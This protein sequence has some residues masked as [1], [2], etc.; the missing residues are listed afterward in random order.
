MQLLHIDSAITGNA[1]VS[2]QLTAKTVAA[3]V[4]AH[5][6]TEVQY[7]DLVAQAPGHFTMDAMAPRTGQTDGLSE[8]QQRENAVSES[9]VSQFLAADVVVVGAPFYNFGIPTQLKAWI[10]RIAQPGR[11][12]RYGANGPEGLAKGKTVIVVSS[13]GGVYSTSDAGRALEHQ[14]SYLQTVFGFFGVTD[15]RFVRAEGVAMGPDARAQALSSADAD[16][17]AHA[18]V[19]AA[20]LAEAA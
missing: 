12:F 16:I 17:Q 6:G 14:E 3:W 13:R 1:S 4:A 19:P 5:P 10:D 8:S 20:A 7:L 2:R 11:T 15:V 9:L 18:A